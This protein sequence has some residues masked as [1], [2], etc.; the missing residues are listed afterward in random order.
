[1][2][3]EYANDFVSSHSFEGHPMIAVKSAMRADYYAALESLVSAYA[4]DD[5]EAHL[6]Q[7]RSLLI[8]DREWLPPTR[9][10]RDYVIKRI[11][12]GAWKPW[13]RKHFLWLFLWLFCDITIILSEEHSL[14]K[15]KVTSLATWEAS[16]HNC[17]VA[18]R[19]KV[20][21]PIR[22]QI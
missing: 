11:A 20:F 14:I 9:S 4:D 12:N 8:G 15:R 22:Q 1:M 7:Y 18:L 16:K 3:K 21:F 10:N 5:A 13:R 6:A 2:V 17:F 19:Q